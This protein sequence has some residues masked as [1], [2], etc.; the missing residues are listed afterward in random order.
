MRGFSGAVLLVDGSV[1]VGPVTLAQ[2]QRAGN[3]RELLLDLSR[4]GLCLVL[5]AGA[6]A[7]VVP[8][9]R[10]A[11]AELVREVL[12]AGRDVSRLAPRLIRQV[13]DHPEVIFVAELMQNAPR[14]AL[15][16]VISDISPF[17]ATLAL[18]EAFRPRA[19]PQQL[20]RIYEVI[21][22]ANGVII[23]YN[24]DR[25]T[26]RQKRFRVIH[27]HG[28]RPVLASRDDD[29]EAL[30][31]IAHQVH[32]PI[33]TDWWL[34]VPETA[35]VQLRSEYQEMLLAWRG[36]SSVAFVG[37]GFG[38]GADGVSYEDFGRN[39]GNTARVHVL[40]PRPD[41]ADLCRQVG[42]VLRDRGP[43]FR[44]FGQDFRWHSL[45]EAVLTVLTETGGTHVR[46]LL[47]REVE[48]IARHDAR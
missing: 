8:M 10:R 40:C 17:Q 25:I 1:R 11:M 34:P 23:S 38:G 33:R 27:P 30:V 39:V 9:T 48:V 18:S 42:Y 19:V 45:A 31:R 41:N 14:D 15:D 36:A 37:Y 16:R 2:P 47:G 21:E 32:S 20:V 46:Q 24:Y 43:R 6:S 28:Q 35:E 44:V 29:R 12:D 4:P 26:E 13:T 3:L 7:G 5:G 22:N